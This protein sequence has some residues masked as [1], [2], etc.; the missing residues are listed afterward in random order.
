M[1]GNRGTVVI[2]TKEMVKI[3]EAYN[4]I[5]D[6]IEQNVGPELLYKKEFIEGM[7]KAMKEV[8]KKRTRKVSNFK[9]LGL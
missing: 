4:T 6:F 8:K 5:G 2:S 7:D 9:E 1:A 3:V